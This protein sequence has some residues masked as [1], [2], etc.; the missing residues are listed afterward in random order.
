MDPRFLSAPSVPQI[1]SPNR[2]PAAELGGNE[3]SP[4]EEDQEH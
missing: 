1:I 3:K 2:E 4:E